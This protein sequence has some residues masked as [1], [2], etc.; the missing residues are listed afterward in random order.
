MQRVFMPLAE[1]SN[2][3]NDINQNDALQIFQMGPWDHSWQPPLF[4][5]PSELAH[6]FDTCM[7]VRRAICRVPPFDFVM[8]GIGITHKAL[9]IV[10]SLDAASIIHHHFD[11]QYQV[12]P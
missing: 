1:T 8:F 10:A 5:D 2:G 12:C 6:I 9:L 7:A 4:G 11:G 3:L